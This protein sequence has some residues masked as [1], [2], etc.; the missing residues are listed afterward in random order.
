MKEDDTDNKIRQ[1]PQPQPELSR[2]HSYEDDSK[3]STLEPS[4]FRH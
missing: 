2:R 3:W 1:S 4:S